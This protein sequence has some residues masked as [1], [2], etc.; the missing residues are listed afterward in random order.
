MSHDIFIS[1]FW[2]IRVIV[3]QSE[4]DRS[5]KDILL[6]DIVDIQEKLM[7]ALKKILATVCTILKILTFF[8]IWS[9]AYIYL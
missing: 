4:L 7:I 9:V 6:L 3:P 1:K 5:E 8:L 2:D